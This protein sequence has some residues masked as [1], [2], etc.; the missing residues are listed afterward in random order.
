MHSFSGKRLRERRKALGVSGELLA[1]SV[2]RSLYSISGY[3][4]GRST[5]SA[6]VVGRMADAL[7]CSPSDFYEVV[8]GKA[9]A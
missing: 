5:P 4:S 3:E 2:G 6:E 8:S 7:D 1:V 9:A